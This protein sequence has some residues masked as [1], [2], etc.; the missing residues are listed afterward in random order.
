MHFFLDFSV[1]A[2]L[3]LGAEQH[4]TS[5]ASKIVLCCGTHSC[6]AIFFGD[7]AAHLC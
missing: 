3:V 1:L 7:G 4:R 5:Y 6:L 2:L